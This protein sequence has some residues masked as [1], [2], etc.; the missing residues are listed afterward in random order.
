MIVEPND[1]CILYQKEIGWSWEPVETDTPELIEQIPIAD[2]TRTW[3][4][5]DGYRF[6]T[7]FDLKH[8]SDSENNRTKVYIS[9]DYPMT[10]TGKGG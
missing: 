4:A 3:V 2:L 5:A 9:E 8:Q 6:C 10:T 7:V 1:R